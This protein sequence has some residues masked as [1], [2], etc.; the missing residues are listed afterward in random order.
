MIRFGRGRAR[1]AEVLPPERGLFVVGAARSGTTILQNALNHSPDVF[2][3]GEPDLHLDPGTPG[4]AARYEAMHAGWHNQP[5]KSSA[6]PPVAGTDGPWEA[7]LAALGRH[8]RFVGTKIVVNPRRADD[9]MDRFLRFQCSRFYASRY[10]FVFRDPARVIHSTRAFQRHGGT[11][12][13]PAAQVLRSLATTILLFTRMT[14]TMPH[15]RAVAH[16]DVDAETFES[17]SDWLGVTLAGAAGYYD[18]ARVRDHAADALDDKAAHALGLLAS[19][20]EELRALLRNGI[21]RPQLEQNRRNPGRDHLTALGAIDNR[22][23]LIET[24]LGDAGA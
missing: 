14:R 12:V 10:L 9:W 18:E 16:E 2:L 5:T 23:A 17:L 7:H 19:V 3:L 1:A 4:F 13:A 11:D 22:A 6:L 8:Y 24:F 15:V 21:D 20:H